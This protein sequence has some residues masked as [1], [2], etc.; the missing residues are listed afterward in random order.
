[1]TSDVYLKRIDSIPG[2]LHLA[3]FA[4]VQ[5]NHLLSIAINKDSD[6]MCVSSFLLLKEV[7]YWAFVAYLHA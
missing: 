2:V 5:I 1:M 6:A 4:C 3:M 7:K